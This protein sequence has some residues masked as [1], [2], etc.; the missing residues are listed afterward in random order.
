MDGQFRLSVLSVVTPSCDGGN[1]GFGF[2]LHNGFFD[3]LWISHT[4]DVSEVNINL[5]QS[6]PIQI[7]GSW[8]LSYITI[9][10]KSI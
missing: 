6:I 2:G 7:T 4:P 10:L 5:L 9:R 3:L 8:I 1:F